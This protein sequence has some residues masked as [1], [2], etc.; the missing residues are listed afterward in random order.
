MGFWKVVG[1]ILLIWFLFASGFFVFAAIYW[2]WKAARDDE[3]RYG[4]DFVAPTEDDVLA[5]GIIGYQMG[6]HHG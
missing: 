3:R 2:G 1:W 4:S 6:R 5:A